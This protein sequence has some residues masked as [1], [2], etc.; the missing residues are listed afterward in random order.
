[1][2]PAQSAETVS[3][4]LAAGVT[5][6][7]LILAWRQWRESQ[8]RETDLSEADVAHFL[9][10]DIRRWIG[11]GLMLVLAVGI[12]VGSRLPPKAAAGGANS[13]FVLIWLAI[14]ILVLVLLMLAL[15]DWIDIRQYA[16]R[17]R[18]AMIDER[19]DLAE[20][21]LRKPA[22]HDPDHRSDGSTNGPGFL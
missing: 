15:I 5:A 19:R 10:Q 11:V 7:A 9:K 1:M 3:V 12:A 22:R 18:R 2:P 8:G 17:H 16:R 13:M 4:F 21:S 20:E 6:V 14:C